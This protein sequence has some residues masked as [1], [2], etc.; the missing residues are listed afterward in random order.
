MEDETTEHP[1]VTV[2]V[3]TP[4]GWLS[5]MAVPIRHGRSL[6]LLGLHVQSETVARNTIGPGNLA[7]I[8]RAFMEVMDLDELVVAGGLRTT[9]ATTP[10]SDGSPG[11]LL[12]EWAGDIRE[13]KTISAIRALV[14]R[15]T[16]VL[17]AKRT[18]EAMLEHRRAFILIP[19]LEI[20]RSHRRRT[21]RGGRQ[22]NDRP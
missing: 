18:V 9:G 7:F 3:D 10:V 5:V 8:V 16:P 11:A 2:I 4:V 6:T 12:I 1:V 15:W 22:G 20:F 13:I 17:R 14:K 19:K 21:R